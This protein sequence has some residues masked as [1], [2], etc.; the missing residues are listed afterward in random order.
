MVEDSTERNVSFVSS[1]LVRKGGAAVVSSG[2]ATAGE[3]IA[4]SKEKEPVG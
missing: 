1:K 3:A 4:S 2:E